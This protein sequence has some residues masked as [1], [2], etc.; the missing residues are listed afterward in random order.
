ME[1]IIVI[2]IVGSFFVWLVYFVLST[3]LSRKRLMRKKSP[4]SDEEFVDTLGLDGITRDIAV[5]V[6]RYI[7]DHISVPK[8]LLHPG[9]LI[10]SIKACFWEDW[11]HDAVYMAIE[12]FWRLKGKEIRLHPRFMNML[13][14][15]CYCT[16]NAKFSD[17][18]RAIVNEYE[19]YIEE[20][21]VVIGE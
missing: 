21:S 17:Y 2:T 14:R 11:N 13:H 18:I 7:A 9:D 10:S 8:E 12:D 4:V 6:R 20:S 5:Q 19:G 15:I 3:R 16:R 1:H